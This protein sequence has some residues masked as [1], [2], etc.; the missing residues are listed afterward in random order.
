MQLEIPYSNISKCS[1]MWEKRCKN[2]L[3][4]S[5]NKLLKNNL[6]DPWI[7]ILLTGSTDQYVI[8]GF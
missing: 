1:K 3:K 5:K 8:Y 4:G 6:K 2:H 7:I